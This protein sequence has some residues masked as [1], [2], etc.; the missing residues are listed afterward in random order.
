MR[1]AW[2]RLSENEQL[3]LDHAA[4]V[5]ASALIFEHAETLAGEIE[6]GRL[7]DPGGADAL[8]LLVG[9]MRMAGSQPLPAAGHA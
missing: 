9:I 4:Q 8:R 7:S 2:N 3:S 1:P 5:R 6:T